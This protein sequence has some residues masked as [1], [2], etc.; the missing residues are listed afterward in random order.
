MS[1]RSGSSGLALKSS[2]RF[3]FLQGLVAEDV[4][5]DSLHR[6]AACDQILV[7]RDINLAHRSAANTLLQQV[8][9]R[10]QGWTWQSVLC[11]SCILGA[12]SYF[13]RITDFTTGALA[14]GG[15]V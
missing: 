11:V 13:I 14:H 5:P 1:N 4:W 15:L 12:D 10:Q 7:A 9:A 8:T 6:D 2:N 3:S